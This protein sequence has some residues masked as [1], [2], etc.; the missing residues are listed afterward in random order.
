[1]DSRS[2]CPHRMPSKV[3]ANSIREGT[4]VQV[5]D[6]TVEKVLSTAEVHTAEGRMLTL[7]RP[8]GPEVHPAQANGLGLRRPKSVFSPNGAADQ[9]QGTRRTQLPASIQS[10]N[11]RPFRPQSTA[12]DCFTQAVGLGWTNGWPLRAAK[13]AESPRKQPAREWSI[14]VSGCSRRR[15]TWP[16]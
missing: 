8:K 10:Q 4:Y 15:R 7:R 16:K 13:Q 9:P 14:G 2:K 5:P 12:G 1:M 3:T 11:G 6:M